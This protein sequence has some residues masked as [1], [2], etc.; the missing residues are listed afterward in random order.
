[1]IET[2]I[3]NRNSAE[4]ASLKSVDELKSIKFPDEESVLWI[5]M[6]LMDPNLIKEVSEFYGIHHLTQEDIQNLNH[7][8][9]FEAF[10]DYYFLTLKHLSYKKNQKIQISHIGLILKDGLVLSFHEKRKNPVFEGIKE[11]IQNNTGTLRNFK[12]D[13]LFY[14][15]IDLTIDE[16]MNVSNTLREEIDA[17]DNKTYKKSEIDITQK[18]IHIKR[19]INTLRRISI[20]FRDDLGRLRTNPSGLLRRSTLIYL[21]DISDHV[22]HILSSV[23]NYRE[24]LKDLMDIHL[25]G[26]STRMNEV[27]KTLTVVATIFIPLTFLAG[28]YGMNFSHMPGLDWRYSFVV[29]WTF[30]LVII[31]LMLLY[32]KWKRWF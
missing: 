10:E 19:N 7:L 31:G 28:V 12:V 16:Y 30:C 3:Y 13:H 15:L 1:M 26:L 27:M 11:R 2:T 32:M 29:F 4:S 22:G 9:K 24:N 21:Q 14:R 17:L 18:I 25:S 20:P 8:P 5:D 23:E 6:D